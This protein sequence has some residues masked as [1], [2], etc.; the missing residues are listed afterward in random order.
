MNTWV[1]GNHPIGHLQYNYPN[2]KI[3]KLQRQQ[4]AG[5]SVQEF[6][7]EEHGEKVFFM[8]ARILTGQADLAKN[9]YG[10]SEYQWLAKEEIE[11][12]VSKQYWSHIR[13][14]LTER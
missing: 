5:S 11:G 9:I 1:V 6:E 13:N 8:K 3:G 14:I 4:K 12:V 7:Q 2:P 10:D